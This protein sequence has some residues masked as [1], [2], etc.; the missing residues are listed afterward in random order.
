MTWRI[1]GNTWAADLL[2]HHI[3]QGQVR[4][5]Y[6]IT[7]PGGIGKRTLAHDFARALLCSEPP[8]GG[9]FC[10]MCRSC[11]LI[12]DMAHPDLHVVVPEPGKA[13]LLVDDVRGLQRKIALTPVEGDRRI[14]FLPDFDRATDNAANALLKT[15]EEPPG[16]VVFLLTA[17]DQESLLP[18]I[19]SRCEVIRL[20]S[21]NQETLKDALIAQGYSA[22]EAALLAGVS[23]GLPG[24]AL[25]MGEDKAA[26]EERVERLDDLMELLSSDIT[27]RLAYVEPLISRKDD[28]QVKRDRTLQL[29]ETWLSFWRDLLIVS[30]GAEATR[31]NPDRADDVEQIADRLSLQQVSSLI[32]LIQDTMN[33]LEMNANIRLVM[34]NLVLKFPR[35]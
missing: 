25:A 2:E 23:A 21:V 16:N 31:G 30:S 11:V 4:H 27:G 35:L 12:E 24:R 5:A 28:L 13:G 1:I 6:L 3:A 33:S 7:G 26:Q 20:R 29:L 32:H 18:T 8:S 22:D 17:S 34:E 14:A 9:E 10:K 19:V 15:L